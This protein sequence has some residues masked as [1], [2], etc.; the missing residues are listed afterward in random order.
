MAS[1]AARLRPD[2]AVVTSIGSE[3]NRAFGSLDVTQAE[4][5]RIVEALGPD[6]IAILNHDDPRVL[7]MAKTAK[8]RVI[9]CGLDPGADVSAT[10]V[11]IDFPH[12]TRLTAHIGGHKVQMRFRLLGRVMVYPCLAALAV[13][14]AEGVPLDQAVAALEAMPPRPG[15]LQL[16]PL[17]NGAW[18]IRD[19]FKSHLE[20]IDAALDVLAQIPGRRI[21]VIG[22]ASE[23]QDSQGPLYRHLGGRIAEVASRIVVVG[24]NFEFRNYARGAFRAGLAREALIDAKHS[25][26]AAWEAVRT[27]LRPGDVVLVKGRGDER[28]DRVSLALLGHEVRCTIQSCKLNEMR[29]EHCPKLTTGWVSV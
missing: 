25:V 4:K 14:W 2:L 16:L 19:D 17:P 3:H 11:E 15:R 1:I 21:V 29:C 23:T 20:T 24:G 27:D 7:A 22:S 10:D 5:G 8:C 9:T 18:L 26:R 13:A 12:G 6:G 28:L